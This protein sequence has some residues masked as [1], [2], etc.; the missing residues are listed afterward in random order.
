MGLTAACQEQG[1]GFLVLG[2][3]RAQFL[4]A[5]HSR[6]RLLFNSTLDF[7]AV[8]PLSGPPRTLDLMELSKGRPPVSTPAQRSAVYDLADRGL[9]S[10]AIAHEVYGDRRLRARVRRLLARR[11]ATTVN[12]VHLESASREQVTAVLDEILADL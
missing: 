3:R 9:S 7:N 2:D 8:F 6:P 1:R 11:D 12:G 4:L 10:R 5:L